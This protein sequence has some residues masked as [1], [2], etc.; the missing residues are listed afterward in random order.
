M[1]AQRPARALR[2]RVRRSRTGE[3]TKM[4]LWSE[5]QMGNGNV[6]RDLGFRDADEM[7]AKARMVAEIARIT[8][9]RRLTQTRAARVLGLSQPKVS[10]LLNG[11][12]QAIRRNG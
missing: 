12:I 7:L 10:A 8:R 6:Y 9:A 2:R 5:T 11:H 3:A 4:A 1:K